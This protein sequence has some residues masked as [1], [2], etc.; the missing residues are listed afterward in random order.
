MMWEVVMMMMKGKCVFSMVT[1]Y[2]CE[3][4][5]IRLHYLFEFMVLA[6][7]TKIIVFLFIPSQC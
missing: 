2:L 7:I 1:A 6:T 5:C 3:L 4:A